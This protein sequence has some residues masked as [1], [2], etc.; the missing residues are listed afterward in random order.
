L[1]DLADGCGAVTDIAA[2]PDAGDA[3][4]HA[5]LAPAPPHRH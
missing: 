1:T 2:R 4:W 3:K 5:T